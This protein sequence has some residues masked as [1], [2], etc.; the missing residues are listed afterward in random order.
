MITTWITGIIGIALFLGCRLHGRVGP[1][2]TVDRIVVGVRSWS[3]WILSKPFLLA[4]AARNASR[5]PAE[6]PAPNL[7]TSLLLAASHA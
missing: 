5:T 2:F 3:S 1:G 6:A 7:A 4:A